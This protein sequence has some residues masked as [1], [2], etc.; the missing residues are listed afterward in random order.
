LKVVAGVTPD[1]TVLVS[2]AAGSVGSAVG[3]IAKAIGC[4]VIGIAGGPKKCRTVR[5]EFG[6]DTCC[7]YK[8][9]DLSGQLSTAAPDGFDVYF[10]NVG[11][12]MLDTVMPHLNRRARIAVCGVLSQYN[13]EGAP[14]GVTNTRLI[15]D[16]SLRIEGFVLTAHREK[17]AKARA[18]LEELILAGRLKYRETIAK[19]IE[20]APAAFIGMLQ[21]KNVGKQLL[22]LA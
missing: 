4:R 8:A 6:L 9:P 18:E 1:D 22:R 3:Q 14:H 16:K 12:E 15:F 19:G 7:D 21:G 20:N 17:W 2:T 5:D 13:N 11:G 10:D